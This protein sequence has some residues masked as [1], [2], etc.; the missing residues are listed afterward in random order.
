[1]DSS[2]R[3]GIGGNPR[4]HSRLGEQCNI[5]DPKP[6]VQCSK[7][8]RPVAPAILGFGTEVAPT[9]G[10]CF[11]VGWLWQEIQCGIVLDRSAEERRHQSDLKNPKQASQDR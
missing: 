11:A 1:M 9:V 2:R 3:C 6:D 10:G 8:V 5:R 4:T 7:G